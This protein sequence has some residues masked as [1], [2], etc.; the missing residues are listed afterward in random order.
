MRRVRNRD[1]A[2]ELLL[3]TGLW[4]AGFRYRLHLAIEGARPDLVFAGAEAVVFV[5]GCFWHGCPDHYSA[6]ASNVSFWQKKLQS[7]RRRD[8]RNNQRLSDAGW[9]VLRIW[10]CE[11][12]SAPDKAVRRVSRVL[13]RR[14]RN[15]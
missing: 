4:S 6:P 11:I 10:E 8:V 7:N 14:Y 3:R 1:T 15:R 9:L 13:G 5:D 2:P 12:E